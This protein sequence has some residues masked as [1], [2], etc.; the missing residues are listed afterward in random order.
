MLDSS[1]TRRAPF[2]LSKMNLS[3][4]EALIPEELSVYFLT[5]FILALKSLSIT[6]LQISQL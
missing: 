6:N 1:F 2:R 5:K 4:P 3:S